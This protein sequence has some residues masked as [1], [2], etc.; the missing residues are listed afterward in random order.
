MQGNDFYE[1]ELVRG[2]QIRT[3]VLLFWQ[4]CAAAPGH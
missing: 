4:L 1:R 3:G 2:A